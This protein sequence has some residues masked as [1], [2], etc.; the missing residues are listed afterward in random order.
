MK[1]HT[2]LHFRTSFSLEELAMAID[3][4]DAEMDYENEDEWIIGV[5]N[6]ID[7]IDICRTHTVPP[8]ETYT[9]L[10]RYAHGMD[11]VISKDVLTQ[12][13]R[14]LIESGATDMTVTGFDT[15]GAGNLHS[16][17]NAELRL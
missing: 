11:R 14:R 2:A 13:A 9:T 10:L 5:C 4:R 3:L 8:I 6:G 15:W 12:I 1:Y 17:A 16:P 7:K